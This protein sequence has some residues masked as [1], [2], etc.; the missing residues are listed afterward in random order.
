MGS[1]GFMAPE[2]AEQRLRDVLGLQIDAG[3]AQIIKMTIA[4]DKLGEN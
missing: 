1:I 3:A 2:Q 4:R